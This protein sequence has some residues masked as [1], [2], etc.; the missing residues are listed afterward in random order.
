MKVGLTEF[1]MI[2][3]MMMMMMMMMMIMMMMMMMMYCFVKWLTDKSVEAG[4]ITIG[5]QTLQTG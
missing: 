1:M 4:T 5:F 2:I 3:M